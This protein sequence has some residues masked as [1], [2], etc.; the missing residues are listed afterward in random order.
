M[1]ERPWSREKGHQGKTNDENNEKKRK[2]SGERVGREHASYAIGVE[3]AKGGGGRLMIQT[4]RIA[5]VFSFL[6]NF[7]P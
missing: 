2:K 7:E 4:A 1:R 6:N 5:G 3:A